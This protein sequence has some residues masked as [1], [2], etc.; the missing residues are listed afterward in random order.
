MF[1]MFFL[2]GSNALR[3]GRSRRRA[4]RIQA[5]ER[6]EPGQGLKENA[7]PQ[8]FRPG[9][10]RQRRSGQLVGER[11]G[12]EGRAGMGI[13]RRSEGLPGLMGD[14]VLPADMGGEQQ[15][16]RQQPRVQCTQACW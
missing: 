15:R 9:A 14:A 12:I 7:R 5:R 10:A 11:C 16:A 6:R 13:L 4:R 2:N 8:P 1:M 3:A